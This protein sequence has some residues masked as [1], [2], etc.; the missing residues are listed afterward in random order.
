MES[1]SD[2]VQAVMAA[3]Q[4]A[5]QSKIGYAVLAKQNDA[6][7][8]QGEAA[9]ELVQQAAQLGRALGAGG[10]FDSLG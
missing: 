8:E 4:S 2:P 5:V 10:K 7:Q 1:I 6:M 3:Q 9:A